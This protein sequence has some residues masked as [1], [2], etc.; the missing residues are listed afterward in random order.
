MLAKQQAK[1]SA[2]EFKTL[3]QLPENLDKNLELI[4]GEIVEKMVSHPDSSTITGELYIYLKQNRIG[5]LTSSEGGY[6]I[7]EHRF[8]PDVAFIINEKTNNQVVAGYRDTHPDLAV[9]VISPTDRPREIALKVTA[10][11]EANILLWVVY[12]EDQE[13]HVY[14][15]NYAPTRILTI[16]DTL[17]GGDV[18]P[19]F[20]L[21]MSDI[22]G[23]VEE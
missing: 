18:L 20:E 8:I 14:A 6:I 22:F 13:I 3:V 15:P 11:Q 9:E 19:D 4:Y 1:I 5:Q 10:Y 2:E 21:P 23:E 17:T 12:P 16:K 7:G